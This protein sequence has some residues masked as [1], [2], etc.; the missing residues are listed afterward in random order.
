MTFHLDYDRFSELADTVGYWRTPQLRRVAA[1]A[2]AC[3][4]AA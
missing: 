1:L 3:R 2:A 4:R